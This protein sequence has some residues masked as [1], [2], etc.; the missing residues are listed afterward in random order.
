MTGGRQEAR[1]HAH[2]PQEKRIDTFATQ[3]CLCNTKDEARSTVTEIFGLRAGGSLF[4]EDLVL[5]R[6]PPSKIMDSLKQHT[7]QRD[8]PQQGAKKPVCCFCCLLVFSHR[9][10]HTGQGPQDEDEPGRHA[11]LRRERR[12]R[13]Q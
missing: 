9:V 13:V 12:K 4:A 8:K 6:W 2:V 5:K 10:L 1:T 11:E 7:Q 3:L